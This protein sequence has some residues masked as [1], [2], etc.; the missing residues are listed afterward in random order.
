[1]K[2]TT[3]IRNST[4]EVDPIEEATP[5]M[6]RE[7]F[8]AHTRE[9]VVTERKAA[10]QGQ[11]VFI[12]RHWLDVLDGD[13]AAWLSRFVHYEGT[14]SRTD[15]F[16]SDSYEQ[17]REE[18]GKRFTDHVQKR[19]KRYLRRLGLIEA[20]PGPSRV[21]MVRPNIKLIKAW[22]EYGD[23]DEAVFALL[24]GTYRETESAPPSDG[25]RLTVRRKASHS[26]TVTLL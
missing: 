8:K 14:Q 19:V 5:L 1:M 13:A 3:T 20:K 26:L 4:G 17:V 24:E 9:T 16:I 7:Y 11:G 22:K 2:N 23:Y 10:M 6:N 21:T 12:P 25:K 18:L 15:G